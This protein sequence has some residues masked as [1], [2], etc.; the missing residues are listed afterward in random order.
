MYEKPKPISP[1][2][3][4]KLLQEGGYKPKD[5][6]KIMDGWTRKPSTKALV[7]QSDKR[8]ALLNADEQFDSTEDVEAGEE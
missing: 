5:R 8:P 6:K 3:F 1:S 2:Q 4:E 7:I